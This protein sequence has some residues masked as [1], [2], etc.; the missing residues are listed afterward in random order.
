M[1]LNLNHLRIFRA[2][3]EEG[4][5]TGAAHALRISQPAVSR[6]L[7][8]FEAALGA[9]L[10]DR[11]PRGIRPTAA[12]EMLG[13]RARRIFA[14]EQGA[15]RDLGELL[16][17][18]RGRLAVGASTTIGSYLVPQV[19]GDFGAQH[20]GVT[21]DLQIGNTRAIQNDVLDGGDGND[22]LDAGAGDDVLVGGPGNDSLAGGPVLIA[23]PDSAGGPLAGVKSLR[24]VG[25]AQMP[26][27]ARE[28]GSGTRD[29]IEA[30]L[31]AKGVEVKPT[32]HLGSTEAIKNAVACGLGVAMVSHLTIALECEIGR[33]REVEVRDLKI[34]RALHCLT[35]RGKQP[36]PA[37][38]HFLALLHE[39]YGQRRSGGLRT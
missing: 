24:A 2:V 1:A 39:R 20:P 36:S 22:A 17:M 21:L 6:Q 34:R 25:L 30:A 9:R 4:S 15:E 23:G 37:A 11:L 18:H 8:E 33:L 12:G 38:T 19:F 13:E 5:I 16:G 28:A 27:I 3:L 32:M 7:S 29:V 26:F 14:E 10:V 35:L 31:L